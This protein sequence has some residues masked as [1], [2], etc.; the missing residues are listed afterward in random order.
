ME[1]VK[2]TA[3]DITKFS[4][5]VEGYHDYKDAQKRDKAM[6]DS[7]EGLFPIWNRVCIYK[8]YCKGLEVKDIHIGTI[9]DALQTIGETPKHVL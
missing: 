8:L 7:E 2:K 3:Q 5:L 1:Q 6:Q 4:E 9:N